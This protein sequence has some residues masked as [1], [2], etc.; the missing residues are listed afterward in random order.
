MKIWKR[1]IQSQAT[2]LLSGCLEPGERVELNR[3]K[4]EGIYQNNESVLDSDCSSHLTVVRMCKN[5]S[6]WSL[7]INLFLMNVNYISV[8][9]IKDIDQRNIIKIH[10]PHKYVSSIQDNGGSAN[11]SRLCCMIFIKRKG[12]RTTG[13]KSSK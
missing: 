7:K 5:L 2:R 10:K 3:S 11:S 12:S 6:T 4:Q 13:S 8:K 9:S 1:Q